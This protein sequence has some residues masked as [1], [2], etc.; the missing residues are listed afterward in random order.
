M[1]SSKARSR[2]KGV[3][4]VRNCREPSKPNDND[5]RSTPRATRRSEDSNPISPR[6]I[7]R[8]MRIAITRRPR[9]HARRR[10]D[11]RLSLDP[12]SEGLLTTHLL[13]GLAQIW[14]REAR[15]SRLLTAALWIVIVC[16]L[17]AI[18]RVEGFPLSWGA[19]RRASV[20]SSPFPSL[21]EHRLAILT[22]SGPGPRLGLVLPA[23]ALWSRWTIPRD[24]TAAGGRQG[25]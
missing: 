18:P 17:N 21:S 24:I 1:P 7:P 20:I 2:V 16:L 13:T 8:A 10:L 6:E 23:V 9:S 22:D 4:A 25:G 5:G 12:C 19:S 15:T 3:R 11:S 14:L